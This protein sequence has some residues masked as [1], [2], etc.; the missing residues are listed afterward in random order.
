[1]RVHAAGA[2]LALALSSTFSL[3]LAAGAGAVSAAQPGNA[4]A[5]Y[6]PNA[7]HARPAKVP[8]DLAAAVAGT[9]AISGGAA[10]DAAYVRCAGPTLMG[11]IVGANLVCDKA[12]TR[13][14]LPG[15]TA[16]CR[17]N[18]GSAS[19]PMSATGHGTIYAWSCRGSRAVAGKIVMPVDR[20]GYIAGNWK[21]IR[22]P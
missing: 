12:D 15:A 18:P 7:A 10:P 21:E 3:A 22:L 2:G 13:R 17:S 1:M 8:P 4:A 19:I 5:P 6:C 16:W 11:C 20:Q 14:A 9:F